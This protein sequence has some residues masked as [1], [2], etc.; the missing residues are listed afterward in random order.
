MQIYEV[1]MAG[2]LG[3]RFWPL[4]RRERPKQFINVSGRD[5][6][7]N[8]TIYRM[9]GLVERE[10]VF[11]VTGKQNRELVRRE[12]ANG[13][14][15]SNIL[16]EPAGRNT[17]PCILY[18]SMVL[19]RERG[20]GVVCV[21]GADYHVRN[22]PEY[23]RIVEKAADWASHEDCIMTIGI[24]PTYPAT[25]YGY[26][27]SGSELTEEIYQVE[28]FVEK[29]DEATAK[30]YVESGNYS[31]NSGVFVF[32]LSVVLEA[33][34]TYLPDMY[35]KME[36]IVA[37]RGTSEEERVLEELY[38]QLESVS[39]DYGIMEKAENIQVIAGDF[40]WSDVGSLDELGTF[41]EADG[42]GNVLIGDQI[43]ALDCSNTIVKGTDRLVALLGVDDVIVVDAGDTVLVCR[44]DR[45]QDVKK[46]VSRLQDNGMDA[47]L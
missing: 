27:K 35:E 47:F 11:V 28:R 25:G 22:V 30:G 12:I 45:A 32:R 38:P 9:D 19:E 16:M 3:T 10:D 46:L 29:P 7:L 4:S 42:D 15:F 43:L 39:M 44:K 21:F 5:I 33:F 18:A 6:M 31:W 24:T 14:P 1:I 40:G 17:A 34:R 36:R 13:I 2:G 41:G 37:A 20:D 26:I 8:E 23:R